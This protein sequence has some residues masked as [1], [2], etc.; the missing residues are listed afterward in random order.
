MI[1]AFVG[2]SGTGKSAISN[3]LE[4][5]SGIKRI[6]TSTTRPRRE[7]CPTDDKDYNFISESEFL[8]NQ[9]NFALRKVYHTVHGDWFYGF[10]KEDLQNISETS[11]LIVDPV[12]LKELRNIVIKDELVVFYL[13]TEEEIRIKRMSER[14]THEEVMRRIKTDNEDFEGIEEYVDFIIGNDGLLS[15]SVI[16]LLIKKYIDQL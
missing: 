6:K 11:F 8:N 12:G 7:N 13:Q 10:K 9:E 3:R 5:I 16:S 1:I 15:V 14:N 4:E 2:K